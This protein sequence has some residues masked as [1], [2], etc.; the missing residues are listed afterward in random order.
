MRARPVMISDV[1]EKEGIAKEQF[2][3][4]SPSYFYSEPE[5]Q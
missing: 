4:I 2:T 1:V 5:A 3:R